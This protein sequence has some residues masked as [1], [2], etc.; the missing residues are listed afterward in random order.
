MAGAGHRIWV[1]GEVITANN[2][3]GYLMD[4]SVQVYADATARDTALTGYLSEGMIAYLE[5]SNS[6]FAYTGSSW[7]EVGADPAV[8]TEGTAGQFLKSLGTAGVEFDTIPQPGAATPTVAGL[9]P[10]RNTLAVGTSGA[11]AFP[12]LAYGFEALGTATGAGNVAV[13]SRALKDDTTGDLNTAVGTSAANKVQGGQMNTAIGF[14]AM[15]SNVNGS[16]NTGVGVSSLSLVTG[17]GNS[18]LGYGAGGALST[19]SNNTVVGSGAIAAILS[20]GDQNTV[21]GAGVNNTQ[22]MNGSNNIILGFEAAASTDSVSNQIT[23]GNGSI[24]ALRCNV[25]SISSLSDQRD[26]TDIEEL[27]V[28]LDFINALKPVRFTWNTRI[29]ASVV[30]P[31]GKV[32]KYSASDVRRGVPDIGFIAQDL[33]EVEDELEGH[34]WLQLTLRDNPDKL[35]ATQG[36]LI[37]IL[38][39]AIQELSAEIELLKSQVK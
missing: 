12:S 24:T 27:P 22:A 35:E 30:L 18:S 3:Q 11:A 20:T 34:D 25:D 38:V 39:K 31:D 36:R 33:V 10:G 2:I 15:D 13:G 23:L 37:P 14:R 26:K 28:G 8:F 17:T 19:G 32:I 5:D 4:Q 16:F 9:V 29:P 21:V 6:V 7:E 1:P